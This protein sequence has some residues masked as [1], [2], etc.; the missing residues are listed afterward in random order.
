MT[1]AGRIAYVEETEQSART[2]F[3]VMDTAVHRGDIGQEM[4]VTYSYVRYR[5]E[6]RSH[7]GVFSI[8]EGS[9]DRVKWLPLA[10]HEIA[11]AKP[12]EDSFDDEV[13]ML[14]ADGFGGGNGVGRQ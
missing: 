9:F 8:L 6:R 14:D 12:M 4:L 5:T 11:M 13:D 1:D 2:T 3:T 7:G 10:V